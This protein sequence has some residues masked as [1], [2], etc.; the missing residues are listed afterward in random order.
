MKKINWTEIVV[1]SPAALSLAGAGG[2]RSLLVTSIVLVAATV[3]A[4]W[5]SLI[6]TNRVVEK[7][8]LAK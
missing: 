1:A 3:F 8:A 4:K 6:F 7:A 2:I 5:G